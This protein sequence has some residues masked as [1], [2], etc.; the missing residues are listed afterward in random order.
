MSELRAHHLRYFKNGKMSSAGSYERNIGRWKFIDQ[1][2][3]R[4]SAF[5]QYMKQMEARIGY[6]GGG[7]SA[8]ARGLGVSLPLFMAKHSGAP[9][10]LDMRLEGDNLYIVIKN[11]VSYAGNNPGLVR[12][13]SRAIAEQ[14]RKMERQLPYLIRRHE[15]LIN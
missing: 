3:I 11:D 4:R 12:G 1:L 9:G 10:G 2:V 8:A 6:L 14:Q 15:K 7:F 5:E 13:V